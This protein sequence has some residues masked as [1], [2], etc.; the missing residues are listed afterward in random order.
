[1]L[2]LNLVDF[3][4][5]IIYVQEILEAVYFMHDCLILHNDLKADNFIPLKH[6]KSVK[7]VDFGKATHINY[8]VVYNL[9][10]KSGEKYN[11][12]HRHLAHELRNQFNKHI[13]FE[14]HDKV[15]TV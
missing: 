15:H 7:I 9:T 8:L 3:C 13:F 11:S 2:G 1:M 14:L 6:L 10:E 4:E 5:W 12:Y